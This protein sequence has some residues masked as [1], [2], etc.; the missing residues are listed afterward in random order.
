VEASTWTYRLGYALLD[1]ERPER[2]LYRCEEPILEL[3]EP[4]ER[5]GVTPNVVFSCS[6]VVVDEVLTSATALP[7]G[8]C[9]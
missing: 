7:S 9:A 2:I 8:S 6:H 1:K 3:V 5:K 4:Y